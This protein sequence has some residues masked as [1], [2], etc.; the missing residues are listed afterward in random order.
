LE[1]NVL[2]AK[3]KKLQ[4]EIAA[5]QQ[6]AIL[7]WTAFTPFVEPFNQGIEGIAPVFGQNKLKVY[8]LDTFDGTKGTFKGFL[9]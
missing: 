2:V 9:I 4:K 3:Y 6:N 8:I 7:Q 1:K 5:F